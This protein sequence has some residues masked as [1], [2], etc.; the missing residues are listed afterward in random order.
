LKS[1]FVRYKHITKRLMAT[2]TNNDF[3]QSTP[4]EKGLIKNLS[5]RNSQ[6][7]HE[8]QAHKIAK[9]KALNMIYEI[10]V[11]RKIFPHIFTYLQDTDTQAQ[12]YLLTKIGEYKN[13]K[14]VVSLAHFNANGKYIGSVKARGDKP[15]YVLTWTRVTLVNG[16]DL[17]TIE[18]NEE[19]NVYLK[20]IV[21]K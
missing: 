6:L 7:F 20:P 14:G 2:A 16:E 10:S 9:Q 12:A 15:F 17:W 1:I 19:G 3:E 21:Y 8:Q 13:K 18:K 11:G 4:K 5:A